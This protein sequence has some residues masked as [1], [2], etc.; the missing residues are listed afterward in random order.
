MATTIHLEL[1]KQPTSK[2]LYPIFIRI[3]KD[4]KSTRIRTSISLKSV[5][6]W[7][8][9]GE[10]K[11]AWVRTSEKQYQLF[12]DTLQEELDAVKETHKGNKDAS[13]ERI[14]EL[15]KQ[16]ETSESFLA[17]AKAKV[18]EAGKSQSIGTKRHYQTTLNFLEGYLKKMKKKDILFNEVNLAFVKSFESYL[19]SV[20]N[21]RERGRKLDTITIAN[22]LKKIRKLVNEAV[23]EGHLAT[24]PFGKGEGRFTIKGK[25]DSTKE[26]LE[27]EEL[28][29]IIALDLPV[30]S[31]IWHTKNAFLFSFYCAGIR[32]GDL[33]QLRWNNIQDGRLVYRMDKNGKERNLDL[34]DGAERILDL[35]RSENA[36]DADFIFPFLDSRAKWAIESAKGRDTME[37]GLQKALFLAIASRNVILNRNL[38]C[39]AEK[40]GIRKNIT[41]HTSRHTFANLAMK[42]GVESGKIQGLLAHS[43]LATTEGYMGHFGK[44]EAD[45]ALEKVAGA[46]TGNK[47]LESPKNA[48]ISALRE[49]DKETLAEVLKSLEMDK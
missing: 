34:V 19:A 46:V 40:A 43:S 26:K 18:D 47:P 25:K 36:K 21:G 1:K 8:P 37:E 9:K 2:G 3:T 17:F 15:H 32:A 28:S 24:S 30:G 42:E 16:E 39:I 38:K 11:S 33:L 5:K 45:E 35:Y 7:N 22:Y 27:L 41:M 4:R 6:D 29:S 31:A 44:K 20:E 14:K 12:N 49:L 13:S 48:L 10:G 23:A